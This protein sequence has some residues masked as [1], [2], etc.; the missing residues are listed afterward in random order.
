MRDARPRRATLCGMRTFVSYLFLLPDG[1]VGH[2]D[3]PD[4]LRAVAAL[5]DGRAG[6]SAR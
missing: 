4:R 6:C 1:G 3:D 2:G 5:Q